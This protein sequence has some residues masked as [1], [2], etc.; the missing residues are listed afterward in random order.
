MFLSGLVV[1]RAV[2]APFWAP[3]EIELKRRFGFVV[4]A[5]LG[6]AHLPT[7]A[8]T[9]GHWRMDES[10]ASAGG[11]VGTVSNAANP[12]TIDGVGLNSATFSSDVPGPQIYD[13]VSGSTYSNGLSLNASGNAHRVRVANNAALNVGAGGDESFTVEFFIRLIEEP[14]SYD[15]FLARV[16]NGPGGDGTTSSDRRGWQV[17]FDHGG[18]ASSYGKVRSRWDTPGAP[19]PDWNRVSSGGYLLVDT[20]NGSGQTADYPT[21]SN[22]VALAGDGVNDL[23]SWHHV[24]LTYNDSTGKFQVWL[25]GVGGGIATLAGPYVHPSG[26]LE[27]GKFNSGTYDMLIDEVRYSS[28]VLSP[29][30]FLQ[31]VPEPGAVGAVVAAAPLLLRRL[32]TKRRRVY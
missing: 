27:F 25:D 17:D 5:F 29:G 7:S 1:G 19:P 4:A 6:F 2:L 16:E 12:G 8:A 9:V 21:G 11:V 30:Q 20:A 13:P 28:G 18:T 26:A 23:A 15:N 22:D 3:E 14:L 10:G 31:A 24:A 32:K